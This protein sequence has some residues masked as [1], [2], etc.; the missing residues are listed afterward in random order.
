MERIQQ[1][2]DISAA[3]GQQE[4]EVWWPLWNCL[5]WTQEKQVNVRF[6]KRDVRSYISPL[7]VPLFPPFCFH[8]LDATLSA[9]MSAP[10]GW[11]ARCDPLLF[12]CALPASSSS[13]FILTPNH[14]LNL[15]D[16]LCPR[17]WSFSRSRFLAGSEFRRGVRIAKLWI[18]RP[19]ERSQSWSSRMIVTRTS[20]QS[21]AV[22]CTEWKES[23]NIVFLS[24][25][26]WLVGSAAGRT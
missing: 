14:R 6:L 26:K 2:G 3:S 8:R 21:L 15:L 12:M 4:E 13:F 25:I 20:S 16:P 10:Q 11:V 19:T 5:G 24:L 9:V 7:F 22:L 1:T 17:F 23:R 18:I